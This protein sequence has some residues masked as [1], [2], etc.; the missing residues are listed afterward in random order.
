[1]KQSELSK[2]LR[3]IVV[4]A[5]A[6]CVVLGAVLI[7]MLGRAEIKA[8]PELAWLFWPCLIFF[9]ITELVVLA[10][11]WQAWRIFTEI[12]RDNSFCAENARRLRTI[13]RLALTDC[14]LYTVCAVVLALLGALHDW[15]VFV[16]AG[17]V[18]FGLAVAAAAAALSHL[19]FKAAAMKDENDLTI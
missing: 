10:A 15:S 3:L 14:G 17:I 1:M 6:C 13:S 16:F 9:W 12:G 18:V 11:L 19:T 5:A 4:A 8:M 2:W 7:P